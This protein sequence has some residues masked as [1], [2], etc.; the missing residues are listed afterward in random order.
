MPT[1]TPGRGLGADLHDLARSADLHDL[2]RSAD[3]DDLASSAS[4][5][6]PC[7]ADLAA[8][9]VSSDAPSDSYDPWRSARCAPR[10]APRRPRRSPPP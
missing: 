1:A 10:L 5:H 3:L 9:V 6:T 8:V 7:G 4:V 2:A